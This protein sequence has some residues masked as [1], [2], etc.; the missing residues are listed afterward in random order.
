[1]RLDLQGF[2]HV[3]R[4]LAAAPDW[5]QGFLG[6]KSFQGTGVKPTVHMRYK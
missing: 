3:P 4:G 1:M 6:R 2:P 5:S